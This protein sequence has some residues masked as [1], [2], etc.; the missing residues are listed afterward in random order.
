MAPAGFGWSHF[1]DVASGS[2]R[3]VLLALAVEHFHLA[4]LDFGGVAGVALLVLP[5]PGLQFALEVG[6][7]AFLEVFTADFGQA[8]PGYHRMP[9]GLLDLV[10]VGV[11]VGFACGHAHVTDGGATAGVF[12]F[13]ILS[14]MSDDLGFVQHG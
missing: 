7:G 5:G 12:D 4:R 10:A 1:P 8:V 2:G 6:T 3:G 14:E 9:L 13:G 11:F